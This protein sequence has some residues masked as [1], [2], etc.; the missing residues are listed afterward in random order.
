MEVLYQSCAGLDVHKE[1]VVACVRHGSG[2]SVSHDVRTFGT[3]TTELLA[4]SDWLSERQCTHIAMEATGV[5]WK[6]VW[7]VLEG[8][9]ELLLANPIHVKN[10]P[11]RKTDVNDATWLSDLLA[12]GLIERSFVPPE[13]IQDLRALTRTRKQFMREK[14]RHV[15]RL[16][17]TLEDANI[18]VTSAISDLMGKSGRAFLSALIAGETDPEKLVELRDARLRAPRESIERPSTFHQF[19]STAKQATDTTSCNA[20]RWLPESIA[21][22]FAAMNK[23]K[24][25]SM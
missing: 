20:R 12:H 23:A 15:Q 1:T 19:G 8:S 16:H 2:R 24:Q 25:N 17:K 9:F 18:K 21:S 10:V 4:L 22:R 14:A 13:P 6:P 7:H 3:T 11:G 5:Y